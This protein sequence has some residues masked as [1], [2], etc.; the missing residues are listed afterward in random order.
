M[1]FIANLSRI[2]VGIELIFSGFVKVVDPYGTGLKLQEYFEVFQ[3]D[4]PALS[5]FFQ[6]F[7]DNAFILSLL[8][9][10]A[11]LSLG[12]ALLVKFKTKWTAWAVMLM[13]LFFTF[14]TFYSAYY[15]K[16]TDCG[17]LV[18]SLN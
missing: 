3:K 13:M 16:V 17:C 11:E 5:G 4:V 6:I 9:C 1:K 18:I 7:A 8:F 2:L 15:N 12:I 10:V 14:L